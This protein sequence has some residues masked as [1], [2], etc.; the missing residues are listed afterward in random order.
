MQKAPEL[1]AR[2]SSPLPGIMG[3]SGQ[4][5]VESRVGEQIRKGRL[6]FALKAPHA[7]LL[8]AVSP[9]DDTIATLVMN[10]EH[11]VVFER[12]N[13]Q[14]RVGKPCAENVTSVLPVN[15]KGSDVLRLF[16]GHPPLLE[17]KVGTPLKDEAAGRWVLEVR[18]LDGRRERVEFSSDGRDVLRAVIDLEGKTELDVRYGDYRQGP[19]GQ[20]IPFKTE[21]LN[22]SLSTR[23]KMRVLDVQALEEREQTFSTVCPPGTTPLEFYCP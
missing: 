19:H 18:G 15:L 3:L 21:I 13:A 5:R 4:V 22:P 8:E 16:Y 2:V 10:G 9:S 11:F 14:C 23:V 1:V 20:R 12:G 17:G 7:L 6:Y